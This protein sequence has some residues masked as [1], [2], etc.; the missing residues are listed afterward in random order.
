M[1]KNLTTGKKPVTQ[2]SLTVGK[3]FLVSNAAPVHKN[4]HGKIVQVVSSTYW[5][6][7]LESYPSVGDVHYSYPLY[8][9]DSELGSPTIYGYALPK[10]EAEQWS[11]E[12]KQWKQDHKYMLIGK[13]SGPLVGTDPEFFALDETGKVIPAF[14]FLP[15]VKDREIGAPFWDGFQAEINTTPAGCLQTVHGSIR[16]NLSDLHA[17][18]LKKFPKGRLVARSVVEVDKGLLESLPEEHVILGCSPSLN[19]YPDVEPIEVLEPRSLLYRTAGCHMHLGVRDLYTTEAIREGIKAADAIAG[20]AM[21]S[22]FRGVE[23]PRRRALY[24]RAGEYRLP[25]HGVEYRVAP[26][27]VMSHPVLYHLCFDLMRQ[28]F[29]LG[30]KGYLKHWKY[31]EQQIREVINTCDWKTAE[32]ILEENKETLR[33]IMTPVYTKMY[34]GAALEN[35]MTLVFTGAH[36]WLD[37]DSFEKNWEIGPKVSFKGLQVQMS[38][39]VL[40]AAA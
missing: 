25:A 18:L 39:L 31:E 37:L 15:S 26:A 14:F 28:A 21:V 38:Q 19:V 8:L 16:K 17:A 7:Q 2:K 5:G 20:V 30:A 29:G 6:V 23:D 35:F 36:N 11:R 32:K 27:E 4:L 13:L 34:S 10:D 3:V 1:A 40:N 12:F 22:L 24:G 9:S 33:G